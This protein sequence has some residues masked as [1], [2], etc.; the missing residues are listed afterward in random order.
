V[1]SIAPGGVGGLLLLHVFAE[2]GGGFAGVGFEEFGEV[3]F[4]AAVQ[5]FGYLGHG[6][7]LG[8]AEHFAG[9]ADGGFVY[10]LGGGH[11]GQ[12]FHDVVEVGG[13]DVE[14]VGVVGDGADGAG[15]LVEHVEE[16]AL[17][18]LGVGHFEEPFGLE[19]GFVDPDEVVNHG[20]DE[21]LDAARVFGFFVLHEHVHEVEVVLDGGDV[22]LDEFDHEGFVADEVVLAHGEGG[23][24][25]EAV[26]AVGREGVEGDD[27]VGG[28]EE[29]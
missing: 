9:G 8:V 29:E 24:G 12:F 27:A 7:V 13:G 18:F 19:Y 20:D 11:A 3:G 25:D 14:A 2:F 16:F 21:M 15:V 28:D 17:D 26:F 23:E 4:G 1:V 6:V 10:P 22:G 5:F